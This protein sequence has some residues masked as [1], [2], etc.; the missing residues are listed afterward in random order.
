M[1]S[2]NDLPMIRDQ[3]CRIKETENVPIVLIGNKCD[4]ETD[5]AVS[6]NRAKFLARRWGGAS[7]YE[8]SAKKR[9]NVDQSFLDLC[10][11]MI[12]HMEMEEPEKKK[13]DGRGGSSSGSLRSGGKK[14]S[15]TIL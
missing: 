14:H 8:T 7:H 12:K 5:R 10:R 3:I 2:L 15:C 11:Q 6:K 13:K 4:L 9:I 1:E